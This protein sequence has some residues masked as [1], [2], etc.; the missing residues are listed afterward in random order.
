[1]YAVTYFD[2]LC[3]TFIL[4]QFIYFSIYLQASRMQFS[5]DDITDSEIRIRD[6]KDAN[7]ETRDTRIIVL[8]RGK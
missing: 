3:E 4:A 6:F 7:R 1:M 5:F 8:P 2:I